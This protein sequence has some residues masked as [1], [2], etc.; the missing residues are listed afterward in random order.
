MLDFIKGKKKRIYLDY[1]SITPLDQGI[2]KVMEKAEKRFF[3]NPGS[4]HKEGVEVKRLVEDARQKISRFFD[5]HPDEIIFTSGGTES[6]NLAIM[7]VALDWYKD[8]RNLAHIISTN[9]EHSAVMET[10]K[11]LQKSGKAEVTFVPVEANGIVD[12]K[13]IKKEIKENT[14]LVSVMYVNNEIGTIQPIKEIAKEIRHYKKNARSIYP[15]FHTDASQALT[16]LDCKMSALGVDMLTCNG[17][18]IYGPRGVG[19]LVKN[20]N[21][22]LEPLFHGG[23][24]EFG[25]RAGTT[26][27]ANILGLAEALKLVEKEKEAHVK[28]LEILKDYA[29]ENIIEAVPG[30]VYNGDFKNSV[31]NILNFSFPKI[32]SELLVLELDARGIAVSAKSACKSDDPDESYVLAA[33]GKNEDDQVSGSIRI[34]FGLH[35]KRSDIDAL[36]KS[37]KEIYKK[38]KNVI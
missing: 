33:L 35:T 7:G 6:D 11:Y 10:L 32:E 36:A 15:I 4:L 34:S 29:Y 20:R 2:L 13:K 14:I 12:P 37:L 26:N 16:T 31:P 17:G 38:Y 25:L 3:G 27:V 18:K 9:I 30:A 22:K 19:I 8:K 23:D 24:Q 1:A 5:A 28:Y 21:I